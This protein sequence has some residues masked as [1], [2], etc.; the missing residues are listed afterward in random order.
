MMSG[1]SRHRLSV[2]FALAA[3]VGFAGLAAAQECPST[4]GLQNRACVQNARAQKLACKI[5]CRTSGERAGLRACMRLCTRA[6]RSDT[7]NCGMDHASCMT[8]CGPGSPPVPGTC[9][10]MC[11]HDFVACTQGVLAAARSCIHD[12]PGG[13]I[14][15]GCIGICA[16]GAR[17]DAA[18][19]ADVFRS[20]AAGCGASPSGAFLDAG[21]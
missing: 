13:R 12:C 10:M 15:L 18:A 21:R 17:H 6:F 19:C 16:I 2:I 1:A 4:C 8:V 5:D 20:C 14:G 11:G 7:R 9:L 3:I